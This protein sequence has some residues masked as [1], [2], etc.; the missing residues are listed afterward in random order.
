MANGETA[1]KIRGG[2]NVPHF[3]NTAESGSVKMPSPPSVILPLQQH[4]GAPCQPT[5]K[6]GDKVAVG[7]V[8][9][10]ADAHI[11]API[12]AT[13]SGIV[14]AVSP[15]PLA[16]GTYVDAVHI[17][18]D[19]NDTLYSEIKKPDVKNRDDFLK[20]VRQSGITGMGGAGFP[21]HVKLTLKDDVKVDTLIINGA[22][23]EPYITA[24][25]REMMENCAHILSGIARVMEY[26]GIKNCIIGIESNKPKAISL[27]TDNIIAQGVQER[28]SVVELP[29]CYPYGAEKVLVKAVTGR[30]ILPGSLPS[31]AGAVVLNISTVSALSC[32]L[33]TGIPLTHK[34]ITVDGGAI[35]KPQNVI[36]PIGTPVRD[37]VNF[38]G[39]YAEEPDKIIIGGPMMGTAASDDSIPVFKSN[40]A[41]LC[42]TAKET[43]R[44]K[45]RA[46]I[47]CS[48]CGQACPMNLVPNFIE[49][50]AE[51]NNVGMLRTLSV[52]GCI[53]CGSCAYVCPA[54][55]PLVQ[56]IRRAKQIEKK[57]VT[58]NA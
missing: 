58:E 3:K 8:I 6:A 16:E 57:A 47:R 52:S 19:G 42:L 20:A 10:D 18:S 32:Y 5:V 24:D 36:V 22:E 35:A 9:G 23:C 21:T 14:K 56:S 15:Y 11:S 43:Y 2:V 29:A 26:I 7:Q 31:D 55:R 46:C 51:R 38:C 12:H 1:T 27:L 50:Y 39:G 4:I 30:T 48:R 17:K 54:R 49:R 33:D 45:D 28:V 13:V 53:E 44:Q 25:Y 41:I 40:N 37:I 34:R